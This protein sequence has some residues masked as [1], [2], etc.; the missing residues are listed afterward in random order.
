M[1]RLTSPQAFRMVELRPVA[2]LAGLLLVLLLFGALACAGRRGLL[3]GQRHPARQPR[4]DGRALGR[5]SAQPDVASRHSRQH[6]RKARPPWRT[7]QDVSLGRAVAG[8]HPGARY[9]LHERLQRAAGNYFSIWHG[10]LYRFGTFDQVADDCKA[11]LAAHPGETIVMRVREENPAQSQMH[12]VFHCHLR[13][14]PGHT[15]TPVSSRISATADDHPHPRDRCGARWSSFR[16]TTTRPSGA[17][18]ISLP[19]ATHP[20]TPRTTTWSRSPRPVSM[21]SGPPSTGI[22]TRP[23]PGNRDDDLVPELPR[24]AAP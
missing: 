5:P 12:P 4:L 18:A 6:G 24:A 1:K 11:F 2:G 14:V 8:R 19:A 16:T 21:P 3:P 15:S 17:S 22:S 13:V 7:C 10:P 20:S 23:T 9:P